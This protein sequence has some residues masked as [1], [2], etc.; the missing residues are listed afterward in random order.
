MQQFRAYLDQYTTEPI[1]DAEYAL[2]AATL[3]HRRLKK[4]EFLLRMGEV[5]KY[6]AFVLQGAFRL[7]TVDGR[8]GGHIV[9]FALEDEWIGD[10]ESY[11]YLT[12]T[13]YHIDSL[14][15][16]QVLLITCAQMQELSQ[17]VPAMAVLLRELDQR[18]FVAAQQRLHAAIACG[19][20]ER[21]AALAARHPEYLQR[22]PQ[23]M[24]ASYL[25]IS[26]ETLSRIRTQ[27]CQQSQQCRRPPSFLLPAVET[28]QQKYG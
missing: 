21:Y 23:H 19:A 4:R 11:A 10:R 8:G 2:V 24:I 5:G 9:H 14:E 3:T 18:H 28:G 16:A 6:F 15:D 7:Y 17:I 12:P 25:G 13:R 20:A 1:S 26:A 27:Q 22:F